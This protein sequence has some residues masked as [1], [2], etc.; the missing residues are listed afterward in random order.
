MN[1]Y[2]VEFY[3]SWQHFPKQL[4]LEAGGAAEPLHAGGRLEARV[5]GQG[6]ECPDPAPGGHHLDTVFL[7]F[8]TAALIAR[9]ETLT[10]VIAAV[11]LVTITA[12]L[13]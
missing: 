6:G 11:T 8:M 10:L 2:L 3:F 13:E 12:P 4:L 5:R 1:I 9:M 7:A